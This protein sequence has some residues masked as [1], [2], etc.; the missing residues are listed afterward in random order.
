MREG[1]IVKQEQQEENKNE[2]QKQEDLNTSEI[3]ENFL[4]DVK[5]DQDDVRQS[6]DFGRPY[7]SPRYVENSMLDLGKSSF[8]PNAST[9]SFM[10]QIDIRCDDHIRLNEDVQAT[11]FCS[12]CKSLCCDS[13]V[14]E[15]HHSHISAAK[16]KVE[17]YFKKQKSELEEL[18]NKLSNSIKQKMI[19][20]ELQLSFDSND[21]LIMSWFDRRKESLENVRNK[22]D[23]LLLEEDELRLKMREI[24]H[25]FFREECGKRLENPLK[26]LES[27]LHKIQIFMREWELYNRVEKAKLLKND[28][29]SEY[30]GKANEMNETIKYAVDM[31]KGK[32]KVLENNL[33][34]LL[35]SIGNE[36]KLASIVAEV[37]RVSLN[38][39]ETLAKVKNI[40]FDQLLIEEKKKEEQVIVEKEVKQPEPE[41][42]I[43][44]EPVI[45]KP[46]I[47]E[48]LVNKSSSPILN[49]S[50]VEFKEYPIFENNKANNNNP[51]QDNSF[52]SNNNNQTNSFNL[53]KDPPIKFDKPLIINPVDL[54]PNNPYLSENTYTYDIF[55]TLKPKSDNLIIYN[56]KTTEFLSI[57]IKPEH[58]QDRSSMFTTLPDNCR[59]INIHSSIL[60]TGG[61]INRQVT[62]ACYIL[63]VS[64]KNDG[65]YEINII[66]YTPM[67]NPR[68]RHNMIH[69]H[70][71]KEILVCSG[72]FNQ[73]AEIT[74][75]DH[76]TWRSLPQ[77][78][79]VRANA[80]IAYCNKKN[81]FVFGGFRINEKQTGEYVNSCEVLDLNNLKV[82]WKLINFDNFKLTMRMSAMGV[83]N[84]SEN[85]LLLCGGFDGSTYKSEVNKIE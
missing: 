13:C 67:Q 40:T 37:E 24:I 44:I 75:L 81:V 38:L 28:T 30:K 18:K 22:I 73:T 55:L 69:L 60:I 79:S 47:N 74:N 59:F 46:I 83:V 14:I 84:Y 26:E 31:F 33:I 32:S 16:V 68:E 42:Q 23:L 41:A 52:D 36:E 48:Q 53:L 61:Y 72:F 4:S 29:V 10:N 82:G 51:I 43:K 12:E 3:P 21:R 76:G 64:P 1:K 17:E 63:F 27:Y 35:K 62:R 77:M 57:Q 49:N 78:H 6:H 2:E 65:L 56:G 70:D 11:R 66:P 19:L 45:P 80:T 71:R 58:F 7:V 39:K 5:N 25:S 34:Q 85:S 9:I 54:K 50:K 8:N 20:S 15:Y